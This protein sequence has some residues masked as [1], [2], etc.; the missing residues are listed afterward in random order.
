MGKIK[1]WDYRAP[2]EVFD[3]DNKDNYCYCPNFFDC[4][5]ESEGTYTDIAGIM[6]LYNLCFTTDGTDSWD[7]SGC[8]EDCITGTMPISNC[9]LGAPVILS[10]PHFWYGAQSM[11]DAID[12]INPI[13]ELHE[14]YLDIDPLSGVTL[15]GHKRIQVEL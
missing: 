2:F 15:N 1:T 7:T 11:V 14:T 3:M 8:A 4:A 9:V 10:S 13:K 5:V 6:P 12:G